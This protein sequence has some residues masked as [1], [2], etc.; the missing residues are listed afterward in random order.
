MPACAEKERM[1]GGHAAG[2]EMVV[3]LK[4]TF[5]RPEKGPA[6]DKIGGAAEK[7][8]S[9]PAGETRGP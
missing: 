2:R 9:A 3:N 8:C 5:R 4:M 6:K 1:D 7:L